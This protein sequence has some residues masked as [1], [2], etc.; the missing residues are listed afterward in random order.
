LTTERLLHSVFGNNVVIGP[1]VLRQLNCLRGLLPAH[2]CKCRMDDLG[3]GDGKLTV[4]LQEIFQPVR[5]RGFDVNPALVRRA[6]AKGIEAR[7]LNL[8]QSMPAGELAVMWGVL[9]HLSDP[10]RCLRRIASSSG[11]PFAGPRLRVS[12][13]ARL[14][15]SVSLSH[16]CA[17]PCPAR[18]FSPTTIACSPS[19]SRR[20]GRPR[21]RAGRWSRHAPGARVAV[22][23]K[24]ARG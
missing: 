2:F 6:R 7:T 3:C 9:H 23:M 8:E 21:A 4:L 15:R 13:W 17:A 10:A 22:Q 1:H 5:L 24:E 19:V 20:P 11:S 12:N 14:C 18:V 16:C